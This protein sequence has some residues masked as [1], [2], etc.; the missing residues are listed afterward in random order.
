M[1]I[2]FIYTVHIFIALINCAN[3]R[4]LTLS[5]LQLASC[6]AVTGSCSL[7]V[8]T[9]CCTLMKKVALVNGVAR[10]FKYN[11]HLAE[12]YLEMGYSV[13]EFK[14]NPLLLFCC[15]LHGRLEHTVKDIVENHDLIHCQS[16]GFFPVVHYYARNNHHKPLIMETPVLNSTTGTLLAGLSL[17]KSYDVKDNAIVQKALDTFCFTPEW[18]QKTMQILADLKAQDKVLMLASDDDF[19]SDN[20]GKRELLH[21]I[22]KKGKHAR[23]FYDNDFGVVREFVQKRTQA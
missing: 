4:A 21:H 20:R 2:R 22:Y 5:Q 11:Q 13:K 14:F 19:V 1:Y 17:S 8:S 18:T 23:L 10:Q 3:Y 15:H 12:K 16:G 7:V 9:V 6:I